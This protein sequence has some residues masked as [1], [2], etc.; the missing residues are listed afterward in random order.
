ME[1]D[2]RVL[3]EVE[4]ST[5]LRGYNTDEV[6]EFLEQVTVAVERLQ[7]EAKSAGERASLAQREAGEQPSPDLDDSIRKT[8]ILAQRTA[9]MAIKEAQ[10]E[11]LQLL[12]SAKTEAQT[13]VEDARDSAYRITSEAERRLRDEVERL[14]ASREELVTEVETLVRVLGEERS[15]LAESL[16][17]TLRYVESS[18]SHAATL[19]QYIAAAQAAD[20]PSVDGAD[21]A[22]EE[23]AYGPA[24][25]QYE[26]DV[27]EAEPEA[28]EL[29]L[30]AAE[31]EDDGVEAAIAEDAA[32]AAPSPPPGRE[33][34]R[35][36]WDSVITPRPESSFGAA[37]S[38]RPTL[39]ALPRRSDSPYDTAAWQLRAP[40]ADWPA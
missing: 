29:A 10:D 8:L 24:A 27:V 30:S 9:D 14:T 18:L 12:D 31:T 13:L 19:D 11:A 2:A 7:A 35:Y 21:G 25:D 23:L 34:G 32:A 39:T 38:D 15:R 20:G 6:D 40:R 22:G 33:S 37:R 3:K 17:T 16:G 26:H 36:D 5:S 1:I 28:T 4:F